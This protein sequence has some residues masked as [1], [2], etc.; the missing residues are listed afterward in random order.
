[1][2]LKQILHNIIMTIGLE[3]VM[4]QKNMIDKITKSEHDNNGQAWSN[5]KNDICI[6]EQYPKLIMDRCNNKGH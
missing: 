4:S 6:I 1:M 3:M 5:F 2:C